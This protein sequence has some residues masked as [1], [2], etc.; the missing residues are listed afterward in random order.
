MKY[1]IPGSNLTKRGMLLYHIDEIYINRSSP[2]HL[3]LSGILFIIIVTCMNFSGGDLINCYSCMSYIYKLSFKS[4]GHGKVYFAPEIFT[5]LCEH[6]PHYRGA[7]G[8]HHRCQT[9]CPEADTA[10]S[11][12]AMTACRYLSTNG[13][14]SSGVAENLRYAEQCAVVNMTSLMER[15]PPRWTETRATACSCKSSLCNT[16]SFES[17]SSLADHPTPPLNRHAGPHFSS[18]LLCLFC[19]WFYF[20]I[21]R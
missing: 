18:I 1:S 7:I 21:R 5:D 3:K 15:Q 19:T 16:V 11:G 6:I 8:I 17:K 14:K 9:T 13:F 10:I 4:L 20:C 2:Y 12:V